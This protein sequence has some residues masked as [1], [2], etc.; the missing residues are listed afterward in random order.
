MAF[1]EGQ[2]DRKPKRPFKRHQS[3][4]LKTFT[5]IIDPASI[6]HA[7]FGFFAN[8][9]ACFSYRK[10]AFSRAGSENAGSLNSKPEDSPGGQGKLSADAGNDCTHQKK[11]HTSEEECSICFEES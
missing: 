4:S 3:V 1:I 2:H 11:L 6:L 8:G 9:E 10:H 5:F 7:P